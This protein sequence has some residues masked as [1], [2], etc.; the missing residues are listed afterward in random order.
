MHKIFN[1]SADC[2][3]DLH[4]MVDLTGRLARIKEMIDRGDYF[5]INRARQYG[6]TT[7]LKALNRYLEKD[8]QILRLDFQKLSCKDFE[9][10]D[11]FV[12]ALSAEILKKTIFHYGYLRKCSVSPIF[13]AWM[14]GSQIFFRFSANGASGQKNRLF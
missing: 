6:K 13:P 1:V 5:T 14:S 3:P 7:I 12:K 11:T 8:Y 2:K 9:N 4:Y 10:E